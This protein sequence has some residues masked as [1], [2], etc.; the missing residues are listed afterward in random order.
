MMPMG[1][2]LNMKKENFTLLCNVVVETLNLEISLWCLAKYVRKCN[3]S[4]ALFCDVV[5]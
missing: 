5:A 1:P 3:K 2:L 4:K